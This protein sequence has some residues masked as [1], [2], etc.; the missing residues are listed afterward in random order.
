MRCR[1]CQQ[2]LWALP[3]RL[4]H[5]AERLEH[6]AMEMDRGNATMA[7]TGAWSGRYYS[8]ALEFRGAAEWAMAGLLRM[9]GWCLAELLGRLAGIQLALGG[10]P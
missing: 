2:Q 5:L 7:A 8:A 10:H 9:H 1:H 3:E 6:G 4:Q